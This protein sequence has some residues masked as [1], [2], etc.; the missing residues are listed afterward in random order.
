MKTSEPMTKAT[1]ARIINRARNRSKGWVL[2]DDWL[3]EGMGGGREELVSFISLGQRILTSLMIFPRA[4]NAFNFVLSERVNFSCQRMDAR[5]CEF[6]H[7]ILAY[8]L[9]G[10][11]FGQTITKKGSV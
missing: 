4:V 6:F 7:K 10:V 8:A 11:K 5:L 3:E 1:Q 9:E 2:A